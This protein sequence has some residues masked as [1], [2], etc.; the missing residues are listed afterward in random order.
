MGLIYEQ[1]NAP[2]SKKQQWVQA[3]MTI[4][5]E[6][7]KEQKGSTLTVWD[8][9]Q[10]CLNTAS[11]AYDFHIEKLVNRYATQC[12]DGDVLRAWQSFLY[13]MVE[14]KDRP[15]TF[16]VVK[17]RGGQ[18]YELWSWQI[19]THANANHGRRCEIQ[20]GIISRYR[21]A[22]RQGSGQ[23]RRFVPTFRE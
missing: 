21:E 7:L 20:E 17:I 8:H 14:E 3:R 6:Q 9:H 1:P 22:Q 19:T 13:E 5:T 2:L 15:Y 16:V 10:N 18:A 12:K 11:R 23:A 4:I